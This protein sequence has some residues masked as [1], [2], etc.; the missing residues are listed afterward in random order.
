MS[1]RVRKAVGSV[2]ILAFMLTYIAVAASIG[3][4]MPD[5]PLIRL[6]Y[7]LAV[8]VGWSLPMIPLIIWMNRGR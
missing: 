1:A 2:V 6:A 8:G 4:R 5:Q 3:G 7:Y